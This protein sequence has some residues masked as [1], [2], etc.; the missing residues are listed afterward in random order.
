MRSQSKRNNERMNNQSKLNNERMKNQSKHVREQK[1]S[2]NPC[3]WKHHPPSSVASL[4]AGMSY[5]LLLQ[6]RIQSRNSA[7]APECKTKL[8]KPSTIP[9]SKQ[10]TFIL[11]QNRFHLE[12]PE[13]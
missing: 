10:A 1:V 4:V 8:N 13:N 3:G 6:T 2:P 11:F 7:L 12:L 5:S 9:S